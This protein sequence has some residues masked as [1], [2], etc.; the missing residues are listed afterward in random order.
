MNPKKL[1]RFCALDSSADL[2]EQVM[3]ELPGHMALEALALRRVWNT[4][5]AELQDM[6]QEN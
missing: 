5:Q 3:A 4:I 1:E 2:L 6:Q